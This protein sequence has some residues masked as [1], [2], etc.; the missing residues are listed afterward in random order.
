MEETSIMELQTPQEAGNIYREQ[1]DDLS[2]IEK[3]KGR[4]VYTHSLSPGNIILMRKEH[5]IQTDRPLKKRKKT[6]SKA[7]KM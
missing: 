5:L 1:G 6:K 3:A 2:T 4:T 7:K